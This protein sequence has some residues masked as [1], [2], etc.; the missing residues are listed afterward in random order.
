MKK[1]YSIIIVSLNTKNHFIETLNSIIRQTYKNY[2][3]IVVDGFSTDGTRDEI[4][5]IKKRFLKL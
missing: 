5:K 4:L 3:I 1:K 2:E